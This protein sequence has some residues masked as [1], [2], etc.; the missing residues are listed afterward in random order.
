MKKSLWFRILRLVA[1]IYLGVLLMLMALERLLVYPAPP[2]AQG[3][4]N[5]A[6]F[7]AT[8]ATFA[9]DDGTH[10]H[11]WYFEHPDPQA[12]VLVCHGNG[13]HVGFMGLEMAEMRERF[14]VSI[15]AFDYRGYGRSG[16]KPFEVGVL[17]DGEAAQCWLAAKAQI[18]PS[19]VVLY[20]RSLGGG[21]AVH[22]ADELGA[23]ALV[24]ERTFHSMVDIGA[25]QYPW[26]PVRWVMRNRYPSVERILGY[27]GPV[28][29]MHGTADTLVPLDS[30]RQLFDA[31]PSV[32][33]SFMEVPGMGHNSET[34]SEFYIAIEKLL[35]SL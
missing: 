9:S 25:A 16:G 30:A 14:Q 19:E 2:V 3:N 27:D 1:L 7:N 8:E 34:P 29:Q 21:V 11:G 31:S 4:W 10:I 26:L 20:G 32:N 28:L 24:I 6:A 23:R 33:K 15:L 5:P 13:E 17:Q 12:C 18:D 35:L 22:L